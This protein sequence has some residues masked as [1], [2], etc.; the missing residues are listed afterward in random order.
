MRELKRAKSPGADNIRAELIQGGRESIVKVLH[1]LCNEIL[2]T[3]KWP[4]QWTESVLITIPKKANTGKCSE[5]RTI[6]LISL[7]SKVMLK[8]IQKRITPR[9][10]EVLSESQAGFSRGRTTVQQITTLQILNEKARDIESL[11]FHNFIDFRKVLDLVWHE[12][13]WNTMGKYNIG[14]GI[15]TLIQSLYDDARSKVRV[16]DNFSDW[17]RTTVGVR[18]GCLLSPTLFNLFLERIMEEALEGHEGGMR[19][20]GRRINDLRFADDIELLEENEESL[21]KVTRRLDVTSKRYGMEVST[22]KSKVMVVGKGQDAEN[23]EVKV[24]I[25]GAKLEQV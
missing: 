22:E 20:A 14:K 2:R 23:L 18:Q 12:A 11:I 9:I 21:R 17:F 6:N 8:I 24:M 16:H 1:K 13:L 7:A 19:C 15:T 10:E 4:N 25:D 5:H 3:T